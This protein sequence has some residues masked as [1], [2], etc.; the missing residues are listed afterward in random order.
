MDIL[1][2]V[3]SGESE[4]HSITLENNKLSW[5]RS[6]GK[7]KVKIAEIGLTEASFREVQTS[8]NEQLIRENRQLKER[9]TAL[10]M[11]KET[12]LRDNKKALAMLKTWEEER[13]EFEDNMYNR[14]LPILNTKKN[15]IKELLAEA[16]NGEVTD[17]EDETDD[18]DMDIE[19]NKR[20]RTDE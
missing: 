15:Y 3:F 8:F 13:K 14:F 10:E 1:K 12:L 20:Q 9:T 4:N 11:E 5:K 7:T 17:T 6:H 16:G 2:E 19:S 18:M